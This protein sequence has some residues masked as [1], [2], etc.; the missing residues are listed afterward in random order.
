MSTYTIDLA[1]EDLTP[2][3]LGQL[4]CYEA[5]TPEGY[6]RHEGKV[7]DIG[8]GVEHLLTGSGERKRD[9]LTAEVRIDSEWY[10]L[11]HVRFAETETPWGKRRA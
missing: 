3:Y 5:M 11:M 9:I 7:R 2:E 8:F 1:P 4:A 6:K 10:P